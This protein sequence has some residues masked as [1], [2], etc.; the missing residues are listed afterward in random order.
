MPQEQSS[1]VVILLSGEKG[2]D[3]VAEGLATRMTALGCLVIGVDSGDGAAASLRM[4]RMG[5]GQARYLDN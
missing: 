2:W 5:N 4:A 1:Q 3:D